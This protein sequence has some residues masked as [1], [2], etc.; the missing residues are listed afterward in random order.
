MKIDIQIRATALGR[1]LASILHRRIVA[2]PVAFGPLGPTD[3]PFG[4]LFGA[5]TPAAFDHLAIEPDAITL[6]RAAGTTMVSIPRLAEELAGAELGLATPPP[7]TIEQP[8]MLLRVQAR[9]RFASLAELAANGTRATPVSQL[10]EFDIVARYLFEPATLGG[11]PGLPVAVL[12]LTAMPL[13]VVADGI[14]VPRAT[15]PVIDAALRAAE[16]SGNLAIAPFVLPLD[17]LLRA[18]NGASPPPTDAHPFVA[19]AAG[20]RV[21]DDRLTVRIEI[22]RFLD[23]GA[24]QP[25]ALEMRRLHWQDF[26]VDRDP[27]ARLGADAPE[28]SDWGIYLPQ[29]FFEQ[30]VGNII[31]G[32]LASRRDVV[33]N[34][35]N[36]PR[37]HWSAQDADGVPVTSGCHAGGTVNPRITFSIKAPGI[38]LGLDVDANVWI[39][40]TMG[41]ERVGGI[42]RL[43]TIVRFD[44]AIDEGDAAL[45]AIGVGSLAGAAVAIIGGVIG[46]WIGAIVGAV[47]GSIAG[48]VG[49]VIGIESVPVGVS[50]PRLTPLTDANG[51]IIPK[52]FFVDADLPTV[53][54]QDFGSLAVTRIVACVDGLTLAGRFIAPPFLQPRIHGAFIPRR[55]E[56]LP[57]ATC[58][59]PNQPSVFNAYARVVLEGPSPS[60]LPLRIYHQQIMGDPT[61]PDLTGRLLR[62]PGAM[63]PN[64]LEPELTP[65]QIAAL[66][67]SG[68]DSLR[69]SVLIQTNAGARIIEVALELGHLTDEALAEQ[70]S[71]FEGLCRYRNTLAEAE[72]RLR[73]FSAILRL[74]IIPPAPI[75]TVTLW[76]FD[77]AIIGLLPNRTLRLISAPRSAPFK[78]AGPARTATGVEAA[79]EGERTVSKVSTDRHGRLRVSLFRLGEDEDVSPVGLSGL[80]AVIPPGPGDEASGPGAPGSGASGGA[81]RAKLMV[82]TLV[83]AASKKWRRLKGA[84]QLPL[85]VEGIK[86]TDGVAVSNAGTRAA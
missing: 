12:P 69:Y 83:Q 82:F 24:L 33:I 6:R 76:R 3:V 70:R 62:P 30:L 48:I 47:L 75:F 31:V 66:R 7:F 65:A 5:F 23:P 57:R 40:L 13:E 50:N 59:P 52:A 84:N 9:I 72:E 15:F 39:E 60:S 85:V 81:K 4:S 79:T 61:P 2:S 49:V 38:C 44:H 46:G 22:G 21:L 42:D 28:A 37:I 73:L 16:S 53:A 43:R 19:R 54:S 68:V 67:G 86:F 63:A 45:C 56:W 29:Q 55:L 64:L 78:P 32:S 34:E 71:L 80:A 20:L 17:G 58:P 25:A 18:V 10:R 77:L 35:D 26:L 8:R 36:R 74:L 11:T 1:H 41:I 14:P 51:D 27:P